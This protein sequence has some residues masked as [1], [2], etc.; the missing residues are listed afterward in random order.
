MK[1]WKSL[2]TSW[3]AS[4]AAFWF[5]SRGRTYVIYPGEYDISFNDVRGQKIATNWKTTIKMMNAK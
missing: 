5:L 1:P 4:T 2:T 3:V